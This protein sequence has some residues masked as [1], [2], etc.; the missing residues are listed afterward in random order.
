[1]A[2]LEIV[3]T[4][5]SNLALALGISHSR[6][7]EIYDIFEE[8]HEMSDEERPGT[9]TDT[10]AYISQRLDLNPNEIF[11][12]GYKIAQMSSGPSIEDLI[13]QAQEVSPADLLMKM[14]KTKGDA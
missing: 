2:K 14:M 1:M 4:Q 8:L 13:G 10:A 3:S 6:Q 7:G 5:N 11:F 9:L 12:L